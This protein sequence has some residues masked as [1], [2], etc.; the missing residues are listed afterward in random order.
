M[1]YAFWNDGNPRVLRT[2][3]NVTLPNGAVLLSVTHPIPEAG[4]FAYVEDR[5]A[6]VPTRRYG[7]TNCVNDG[8]TITAKIAVEDRDLD[9]VRG[10]KWAA[11]AAHRYAVETGGIDVDGHPIDTDRESQAGIAAKQAYLERH[12]DV[13]SVRWKTRSGFVSYSHAA[14]ADMSAAVLFHVQSC[15]D[16]EAAHAEAIGAL[17]TVK[18]IANYDFTSGW[19]EALD[20]RAAPV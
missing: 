12:A 7:A 11:L 16:T 6:L 1:K 4:L 5:P 9:H 3:K 20:G 19:P 17:E 14:F 8:W 13:S 15:F 2:N 18:D 10:E